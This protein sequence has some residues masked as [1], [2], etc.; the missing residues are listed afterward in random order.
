[1]VLNKLV[2]A[3]AFAVA[4]CVPSFLMATSALAEPVDQID[5]PQQTVPV[6]CTV[7]DGEFPT[8]TT[9]GCDLGIIKQVSVNGGAFA[10][11][12]TSPDAVP[13]HVGDTVTWKI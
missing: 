6:R 7:Q 9:E 11:A 12:D 8:M 13:A 10:D 2:R 1:M 4:S 5:L 3:V